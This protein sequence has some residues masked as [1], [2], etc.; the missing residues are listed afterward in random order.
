MY[1]KIKIFGY[2]FHP[3]L[4][5]YPVVLYTATLIAFVV[6][7]LQ[8]EVFWFRLGHVANKAGVM[9]ALVT[10]APGVLSWIVNRP[11]GARISSSDLCY[12]LLNGGALALFTLTAFLNAGKWDQ[13]QPSIG[14]PLALSI[15]GVGLTIAAGFYGW[16]F[17]QNQ[18]T[19]EATLWQW[20]VRAARLAEELERTRAE[21][22]RVRAELEQV[23]AQRVLQEQA[24]G[25][26]ERPPS[27]SAIANQTWSA[28][29]DQAWFS[30]E[31]THGNPA[32]LVVAIV[33]TV[34]AVAFISLAPNLVGL[35]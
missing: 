10:L 20:Q 29:A 30:A 7:R 13:P 9:L 18:H 25:E 5:A 33:L 3:M 31:E 1:I 14:L 22:D 32:K 16:T 8:G 27:W 2:S 11:R 4:V 21:L 19:E 26:P 23:R 24:L 28:L 34:G 15:L 35:R 6:Y 17:V 12:M